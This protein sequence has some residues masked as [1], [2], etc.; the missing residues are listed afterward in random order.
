MALE[1]NWIK[2]IVYLLPM[3]VTNASA[4][5]FSGK[6]PLDFG[7]KFLDGKPLLG[8]GK[9]FRGTLFS[10][11]AGFLTAG[12][13][14]YGFP[15]LTELLSVNYLILAGLLCIGTHAGDLTASFLKRRL[16]LASG[17]EVLLLDQL[18]FLAGA[19]ILGSIYYWP[20]LL[21]ISVMIFL[22]L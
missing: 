4:V 5:L 16:G 21:E 7:V 6:T 17:K 3:Y 14:F 22:T 19:L 8:K 11:F 9:T 13:L 15:Q 10:L 12:I 18:D 20:S 1:L 2:L